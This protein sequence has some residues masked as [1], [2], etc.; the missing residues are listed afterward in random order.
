MH[1]YYKQESKRNTSNFHLDNK[2]TT[3][4]LKALNYERIRTVNIAK[5]KLNDYRITPQELLI[6]CRFAL[7][8]S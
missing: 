1:F 3:N 5:G 4:S 6:L 2:W 8:E 7:Q